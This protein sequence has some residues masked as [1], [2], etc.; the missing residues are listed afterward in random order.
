M[1]VKNASFVGQYVRTRT[2]LL[3]ALE[4]LQEFVENL[5]A[6]DESGFIPNLD[7]GHLGS[8][9]HMHEVIGEVARTA[10]EMFK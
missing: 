7:Y 8:L 3:A 1:T 5:P 9:G 2:E 6:P 4:N 10:D